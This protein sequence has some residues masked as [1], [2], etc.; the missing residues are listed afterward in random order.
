[1]NTSTRRITEGAMM[2][3]IVGLF[4]FI[5][6]QLA[7]MLELMMY[8]L[9]SFPVLIYTVK[10]GWKAAL[11]PSVAMLLLSVMISMPTTIF[12]LAS[13]LLCGVVY[14][15][16]VRS[17]WANIVLLVL[18][19]VFTLT[20]YIITTILFASVFGYDVNEDL[21]LAQQMG[22][23]LNLG[24]V[25]IVQLTFCVTVILTVL[26]SI[27]QTICVHLLAVVIL[28]RMKLQAPQLKSIFDC[29]M[30]KA[31]GWISIIIWLLFLLRNVLK[32]EGNI[33]IFIIAIYVIDLLVLLA[34]CIMDAMCFAILMR[35]SYLGMVL[36]LLCVGMMMLSWTRWL[37]A[38]FAVASI[39]S[40][41]R[42][43]WKRG[44]T[45]G[46]LGKS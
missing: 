13:A 36:T 20:S 6:Q 37:M 1:M 40:E 22:E 27:L 31:V 7:G 32:L 8:W 10:Y 19:F 9:L 12:Y 44:V 4:L 43:K 17:Q 33:L 42:R 15:Q 11:V 24:N 2:V 26:S 46:T 25:N 14:G 23:Y 29:A 35:R 18:T 5:N 28:R 21:M 45:N 38:F 41:L 3:A 30:P 16:G 34:E 39:M